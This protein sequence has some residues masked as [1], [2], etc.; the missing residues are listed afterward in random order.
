MIGNSQIPHP[1]ESLE[2]ENFGVTAASHPLAVAES[3]AISAH[4]AGRGYSWNGN[5]CLEYL[6]LRDTHM[7]L[8]D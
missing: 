7:G 5:P 2:H 3:Q 6:P 1:L 4:L 8:E